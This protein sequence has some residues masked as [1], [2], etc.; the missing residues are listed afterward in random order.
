MTRVINHV[1]QLNILIIFV[2]LMIESG[3]YCVL[4]VLFNIR[5]R[6][7]FSDYWIFYWRRF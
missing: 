7:G 3:G 2:N 6:L 1:D 5:C 4:V